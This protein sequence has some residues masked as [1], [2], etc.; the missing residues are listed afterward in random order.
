MNT[1]KCLFCGVSTR[2]FDGEGFLDDSGDSLCDRSVDGYHGI[3][4]DGGE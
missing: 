2:F 3:D 1:F 4:L